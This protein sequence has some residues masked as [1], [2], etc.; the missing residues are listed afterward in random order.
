MA[1]PAHPSKIP[2]PPPELNPTA[3]SAQTTPRSALPPGSSPFGP[4]PSLTDKRRQGADS[5]NPPL[6]IDLPLPSA[7]SGLK[8][9][10]EPRAACAPSIN[11]TASPLPLPA[12]AAPARLGRNGTVPK[13]PLP[14]K[15]ATSKQPAYRAAE[16]GYDAGV[17]RHGQRN[18]FVDGPDDDDSEDEAAP[19]AP[20]PKPKFK[21]PLSSLLSKPSTPSSLLRDAMPAFPDLFGAKNRNPSASSHQHPARLPLHSRN[22]HTGSVGSSRYGGKKSRTASISSTRSSEAINHPF[23]TPGMKKEGQE[24]M[25]DEWKSVEEKRLDEDENK[26]K[27]WKRWGPYV[28]ERQWVR[29]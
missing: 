20:K 19:G 8:S 22:S 18:D 7:S 4:P 16:E 24:S 29:F 21:N 15:R 6:K 12:A 23:P 28:S 25:F 26:E 11:A 5:T 3:A 1:P 13:K 2:I 14:A 9:T 10:P 27:H 17:E